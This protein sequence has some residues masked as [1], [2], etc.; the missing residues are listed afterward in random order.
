MKSLWNEVESLEKWISLL[1][2]TAGEVSESFS[3]NGSMLNC[4][5]YEVAEDKLTEN[6]KAVQELL[7]QE[8]AIDLHRASSIE[9]SDSLDQVLQ[10]VAV[11]ERADFDFTDR[12]WAIVRSESG[13]IAKL[14]NLVFTKLSN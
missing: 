6:I 14:F 8:P 1:T 5:T 4:T 11:Q 2:C 12:V 9:F 13:I 10:R 7:A 3:A